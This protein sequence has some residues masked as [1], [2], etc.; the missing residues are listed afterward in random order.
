MP[1]SSRITGPYERVLSLTAQNRCVILD[2]GVSTELEHT[3]SSGPPNGAADLWGTWALYTDS[4]AVLKVHRRYAEAGCD[5]V[6]TNTW[7]IL[8]APEIDFR[9]AVGGSASHWMNAA[10]LGVRLA[11]QAIAD[12]GRTGECAV[13]FTISEEVTNPERQRTVQLLTRVF[14]D[15]PPDLILMET[16][17]LLREQT[18][19]A[20]ETLLKTGIPVWLSFRRCLHGACGVYGQ[21]WGGPEGD[22]FG[23]SAG[24]FEE[25][26]VGALLINCIPIDHVPGILPWLRDFTDLPLGVYPNLGHLGGS[27]W[28]FDDRTGPKEYAG[29]AMKWRREGAQIIGGCCGVTPDHIAAAKE[30]LDDTTAPDDAAQRSGT[31]EEGLGLP[32]SRSLF[33]VDDQPPTEGVRPWKDERSRILYPLPFPELTYDKGV[34][35][36]TQGSLLMWRYLLRSGAGEGKRCLDVG[37]GAGILAIQLALNGA[38]HV[39]AI[40]VER[41]A[42]NN[43]MANAYRNKVADRISGEEVDLYF[44]EPTEA[45]DLI[46]A[47]LYQMPVDPFQEISGHRPLDFWGR[48]LQ[49]QLF[50][51]LP[52]AMALGGVAYV[53][54]LSIISQQQTE[55]NLERHGLKARV[56]DFTFFPF[57]SIFEQ[58]KAQILRVEELSDAYHLVIGSDDILVAYALEITRE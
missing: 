47:S 19:T 2:G 54:Q 16:L 4:Q 51:R 27:G 31:A 11:R 22:L 18:F 26:G 20:V 8:S 1:S 5:I 24:R 9:G 53:M 39:D 13:A 58:N 34:F 17:A 45:Y 29:L 35:A 38:E 33:F 14:E 43:T 56:V 28:R 10:R 49:D 6:S 48:N 3:G 42:V 55:L 44:W 37:C 25:M 40:D 57:S 36:P 32:D 7:S 46:V 41:L 30:A 50:S 15:A 23:R 12:S 52:L 21:H